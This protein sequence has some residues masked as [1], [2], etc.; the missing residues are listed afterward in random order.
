MSSRTAGLELAT[1]SRGRDRIL[2][3]PERVTD[4]TARLFDPSQWMAQEKVVATYH[5][6]GPTYV[7]AAGEVEWVLRHLRRGGFPARLV[8]DRYLWVGE[9]RSRPFREL[10]ILAHLAREGFPVPHPV[11]AG[12]WRHGLMYDGDI[13]TTRVPG[14]PLSLNLRED[15]PSPRAWRGIGK[16]LR[17]FHERGVYHADLSAGNVLVGAEGVFLIDFDRA[18]IRKRG[19]WMQRNLDRLERSARKLAGAERWAAPRWQACWSAL[20]TGYKSWNG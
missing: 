3:D 14:E 13:I 16:T 4:P 2:F 20:W 1:A 12:V 15:R 9:A 8:E 5:G 6:R 10:R 11:A 18:R 19:R 7:L 17:R